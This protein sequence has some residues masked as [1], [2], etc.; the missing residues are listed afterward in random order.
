[1]TRFKTFGAAAV[2]SMMTAT[3]L[4][5]QAAVQEPGALA[6]YHPN[7]DVL[8][9]GRTTP[10]ASGAVASVPSGGSDAYASMGGNANGSSCAQ[11]YRSY[12]SA[13]GTFLGHDGHRHPCE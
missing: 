1:M 9:G 2:L 12:D 5:A 4:F 3:P 6:F 13:S 8:N 10:A 7:A 11:R